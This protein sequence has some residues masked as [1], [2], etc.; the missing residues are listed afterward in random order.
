MKT[1]LKQ[2]ASLLLLAT[3]CCQG[4]S[5]LAQGTAFTYQGLLNS[6]IGPVTG[7]YDLTFSLFTSPGGGTQVG[8]TET[9]LAVGVTNGLFM[10]TVDFGPGI[11]TGP[12]LWLGIGVR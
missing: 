4:S 1:K 12:P 3:I 2:I 9:N 6:A 10:S 8:S 7:S 5:T 11:F